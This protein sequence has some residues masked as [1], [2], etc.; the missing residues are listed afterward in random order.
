MHRDCLA[1]CSATINDPRCTITA[2]ANGIIGVGSVADCDPPAVD[3]NRATAKV[4]EARSASRALRVPVLTVTESNDR[5]TAKSM[6]TTTANDRPLHFIA[7][8]L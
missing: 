1:L 8:P 6:E 3:P 2:G 5:K 4:R 7:R